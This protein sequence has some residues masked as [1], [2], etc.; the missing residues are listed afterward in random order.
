MIILPNTAK[1]AALGSVLLLNMR[2]IADVV[3]AVTMVAVT[4]GTV[5]EFQLGV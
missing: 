4:P 5:A 2:V 1:D 3:L